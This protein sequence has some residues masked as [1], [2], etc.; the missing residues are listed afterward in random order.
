VIKERPGEPRFGFDISRADGE[1]IETFNDL[2]W[3]DALPGGQP[4]D[5]VP[6]GNLMSIQLEDPGLG[7]DEKLDQ[8]GEDVKV[9][10]AAPSSARWATILFQAPVMVAVHAAEMLR[11]P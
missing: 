5:V 2:A 9:E 10:A 1:P 3:D 11:R 6:A 7:D 8:H 4:G